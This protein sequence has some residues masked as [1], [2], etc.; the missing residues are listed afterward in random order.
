[1]HPLLSA[2]LP[3]LSQEALAVPRESPSDDVVARVEQALG[4]VAKLLGLPSLACSVVRTDGPFVALPRAVASAHLHFHLT[5]LVLAGSLFVDGR[6]GGLEQ[7]LIDLT[8][9]AEGVAQ[10]D[11]EATPHAVFG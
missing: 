11:G 2:L 10:V 3:V 5:P 8:R 4:P 6:P 9:R 1:V 7:V